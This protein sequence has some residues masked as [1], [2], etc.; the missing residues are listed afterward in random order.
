MPKPIRESLRPTAVANPE[1][2]AQN[3]YRVNFSFHIGKPV[4]NANEQAVHICA[5]AIGNRV[6]SC[7]DADYVVHASAPTRRASLDRVQG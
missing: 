1:P 2:Q 4:G 5:T 6:Q 3:S 7:D